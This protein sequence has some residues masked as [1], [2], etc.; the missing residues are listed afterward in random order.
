MVYSYFKNN[1][2]SIGILAII[3]IVFCF[4]AMLWLVLGEKYEEYYIG[5][6]VV[7]QYILLFILFIVILVISFLLGRIMLAKIG[8]I[9]LDALSTISCFFIPLFLFIFCREGLMPLY[10]LVWP[11]L[12]Y[13][14]NTTP[15]SQNLIFIIFILSIY[16]A[17]TIG[18]TTKTKKEK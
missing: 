8:N 7:M 16:L 17:I 4:P 6:Y 13:L 18:L 11:L 10:L 2:I 12:I 1:I 3:N 9:F 14:A 5:K 15:L